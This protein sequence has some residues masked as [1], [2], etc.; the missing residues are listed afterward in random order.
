MDDTPAANSK[1][2]EWLREILAE[3]AAEA[4]A[5][6]SEPKPLDDERV[7]PRWQKKF[8]DSSVLAKEAL[9]TGAAR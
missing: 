3:P 7:G 9:R 2:R 1:T 4:S 6:A 5:P 8:V